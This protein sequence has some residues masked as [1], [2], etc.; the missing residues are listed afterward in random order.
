[1]ARKDPGSPPSSSG[2]FRP[3]SQDHR[4][5]RAARIQGNLRT[6]NSMRTALKTSI[7]VSF[8]NYCEVRTNTLFTISPRPAF[9]SR[10]HQRTLH[11]YFP[12]RKNLSLTFYAADRGQKNLIG[13]RRQDR[14]ENLS[15]TNLVGLCPSTLLRVVS[16][17]FESLRTVSQFEWLNHTFARDTVFLISFSSNILNIFG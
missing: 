9:Q 16:L 7:A 17:S 15:F 14:K 5:D 2:P 11:F 8:P 12:K 1:M 4:L 6:A 3:G 13:P 10:Q